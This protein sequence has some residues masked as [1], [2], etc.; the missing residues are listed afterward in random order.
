[1]KTLFNISQRFK[2][3]ETDTCHIKRL[4]STNRVSVMVKLV[5]SKSVQGI[6]SK[7]MYLFLTP[8]QF[9]HSYTIEMA[10]RLAV[11]WNDSPRGDSVGPLIIRKQGT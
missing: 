10:K 8:G 5:I 7:E 3:N 11:G 1:M 9:L 4:N 6:S 2:I